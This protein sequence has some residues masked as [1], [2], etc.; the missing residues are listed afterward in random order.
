MNNSLPSC[1]GFCLKNW[2]TWSM[3]ITNIEEEIGAKF[4]HQHPPPVQQSSPTNTHLQSSSHPL[5]TTI[6]SQAV[7]PYQ[8]QPPVQQSS[9]TNTNLQSSNHPIPTPTFSPAVPPT[10]SRFYASSHAIRTQHKNID[11][12]NV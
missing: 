12:M 4:I 7:T 1:H 3:L 11:D 6:S 8:H 9:P 2:Q 10:N 5:P